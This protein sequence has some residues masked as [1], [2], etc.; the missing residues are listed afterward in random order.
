MRTI[1]SQNASEMA[2]QVTDIRG[3]VALPAMLRRPEVVICSSDLVSTAFRA[4]VLMVR[5]R[6]PFRDHTNLV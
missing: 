5:V 3:M 6:C 1:F 4:K 2:R